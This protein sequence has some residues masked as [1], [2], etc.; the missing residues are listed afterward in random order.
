MLIDLSL[1]FLFCSNRR[2]Y[3]DSDEES[4]WEDSDEESEHG[5]KAFTALY[6]DLKS[7]LHLCSNNT[8]P[9]EKEAK[10]QNATAKAS[11]EIVAGIK[12]QIDNYPQS[13]HDSYNSLREKLVSVFVREFS[14]KFPKGKVEQSDLLTFLDCVLDESF[15][16]LSLNLPTWYEDQHFD[17]TKLV[18]IVTR[19]CPLLTKVE[20]YFTEE[21]VWN[22]RG[23]FKHMTVP[24]ETAFCRTLYQLKN[25]TYI[26]IC[27][28]SSG[29]TI[30][31]FS[32]LGSSCPQMKTIELAGF[33]CGSEHLLA[34]ILGK[35]AQL[36]PESAKKKMWGPLYQTT[37]M[38]NYS[39]DELKSFLC[40]LALD[41]GEDELAAASVL[42]DNMGLG[43]NQMHL[44]QFPP[45]YLSPI[46]GSLEEFYTMN[47]DKFY[48]NSGDCLLR[49]PESFVFAFRHL[50]RLKLLKQFCSANPSL[51]K[52][53][54]SN[55][56][57]K[58][59]DLIRAIEFLH[60]KIQQPN[61]ETPQLEV[62]TGTGKNRGFPIK[63][64]INA[65][66]PSM[67]FSSSFTLQ[68]DNYCDYYAGSL[69]VVKLDR[70]NILSRKGMLAVSALCPNLRGI[71]FVEKE[72]VNQEDLLS[73]TELQSVLLTG[74]F[75]VSE[76]DLNYSGKYVRLN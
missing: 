59:P 17:T 41:Q 8:A 58:S 66:L 30:P 35:W 36:F 73:L 40:S 68:Y 51:E 16:S 25:L 21:F 67:F 71:F 62:V 57:S 9:G 65:P 39:A 64:T 46:C 4:Y 61:N 19:Q 10:R 55:H 42:F 15:T 33:A 22:H 18:K 31:F 76:I 52:E 7:K 24:M 53:A 6:E 12:N 47:H 38:P 72:I 44:Y 45:E 63:W 74:Q 50:S 43:K 54:E 3:W 28:K 14:I 5:D 27:W 49:Q 20:F 29:N 48:C 70:V 2:M 34:L 56:L 23:P 1:M 26:N 75:K 69:A 32:C 37:K 60:E 13:S 11:Q